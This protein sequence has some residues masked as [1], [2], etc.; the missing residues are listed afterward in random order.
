[1]E[2]RVYCW[3][4]KVQVQIRLEERKL[5]HMMEEYRVTFKSGVDQ[6]RWEETVR[7]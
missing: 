5:E 2:T 6:R 7:L 4:Y 3:I 1:M